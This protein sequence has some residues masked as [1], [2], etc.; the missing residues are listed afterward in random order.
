MLAIRR[1]C[2]WCGRMND[3][4]QAK[5]NGVKPYCPNC[6]HRADIEPDA[7]DCQK[8]S[9]LKRLLAIHQEEERSEERKPMIDE[10]EKPPQPPTPTIPPEQLP[11][12]ED[13]PES[14]KLPGAPRS[15]IVPDV[16][17]PQEEKGN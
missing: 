6:N 10:Q 12:A 15:P 5:M 3:L 8:C 11:P 7:C 16:E 14:I 1:V 17:E 9:E 4:T 2:S 13:S